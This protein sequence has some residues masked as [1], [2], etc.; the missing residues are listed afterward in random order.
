MGYCVC[1]LKFLKI[2]KFLFLDDATLAYYSMHGWR[3]FTV[4]LCLV[5]I[6]NR[7]FL[8]LTNTVAKGFGLPSYECD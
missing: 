5:S 8:L 2:S 3:V 7:G 1:V 4:Q 6:A